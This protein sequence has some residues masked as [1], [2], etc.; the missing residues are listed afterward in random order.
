MHDPA[1]YQVLPPPDLIHQPLRGRQEQTGIVVVQVTQAV[2]RLQAVQQADRAAFRFQDL[3]QLRQDADMLPPALRVVHPLPPGQQLRI[4]LVEGNADE[5]VQQLPVRLR[6]FHHLRQLR[7]PHRRRFGEAAPVL[8]PQPPVQD[9]G[10]RQRDA[11]EGVRE[12]DHAFDQRH[13]RPGQRPRHFTP[14]AE[15]VHIA[16]FIFPVP[17]RPP[18]DLP[19]LR[20]RQQPYALPVIL[21]VLQEHHPPDRQVHAHGDG[22]RRHHDL[23]LALHEAVRLVPPHVR[24]QGSVDQGNPVS[25]RLQ[26]RGHGVH[27]GL[28]ED[29]QRVP[30]LHRVRKPE[31]GRFDLQRRHPLMP[32]HR[33]FVP[34]FADDPGQQLLRVRRGAGVDLLRAEPEDR[35]GPGAAPVPVRD[36]LALVDHRHVVAGLQVRHLDGR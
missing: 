15:S 7:H 11:Q 23:G 13:Q 20:V 12:T 17:P 1:G 3:R 33:Q 16:D 5:P 10:Q 6:R 30:R 22:V 36:H 25:P 34:A 18:G 27:P 21:L 24:R 4:L 26:L 29:D 35:R 14:E 9:P 19:D 8:H 32:H 28:G 2:V 31:S